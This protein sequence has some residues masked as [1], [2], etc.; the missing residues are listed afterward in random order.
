VRPALDGV[1]GIAILVFLLHNL[2]FVEARATLSEKLWT[3][4]VEF[5][6]AGISL[7][8]VLTGFLVTEILLEDKGKPGWIRSFYLRRVL[9]VV[10]L[11][12]AIILAY[13]I[14]GPHL[15][16]SLD[17]PWREAIWYWVFA[18]NWSLLALGER[19][20]LG[21]SWAVGAV[22]QFYL[23]WPLVVGRLRANALAVVCAVVIVAA[24]GARIGLYLLGFDN[25][26]SYVSTVTRADCFALG[27]LVALA[28]QSETWRPKLARATVSVLVGSVA[29]IG[30]IRVVS[31]LSRVSP[32]TYTL[33]YSAF[34]FG[35]AGLVALGA[36]PEPPR[37]LAHPILAF[38]GRHG[39]ALYLLH[40]PLKHAVLWWLG[41]R[42]TLAMS[43]RPVVTDVALVA[44]LGIG[45][46]LLAVLADAALV[47]PILRRKDVWAPRPR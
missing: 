30:V 33:G 42:L 20:G 32:L 4:V 3:A 16:P 25:V 31:G 36:R 43:K 2:S 47:G 12:Y 40:S 26:W 8:F 37:W 34:A 28:M 45:S 19:D 14:V 29:L 38:M 41:S 17:I 7:G 21:P 5:G 44:A 22:M 11:F 18:N 39:Y 10:P 35:S 13:V 15:G 23:V 1:R 24:L 46:V 6:W 9:R 27:A